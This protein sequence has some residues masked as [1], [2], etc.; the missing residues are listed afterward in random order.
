MKKYDLS[1]LTVEDFPEGFRDVVEVIGVEAAYKLCETFGGNPFYA[2]KSDSITKR[3]RDNSI[4]RDYKNGAS[5][6]QL[7]L[8]YNL[9]FN[10]VRAICSMAYL[11]Q[12]SINEYLDESE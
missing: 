2:P 3:L 7:C 5:I 8:D 4:K 1:L 11:R 9:S 10:Q 12:M 6:Q